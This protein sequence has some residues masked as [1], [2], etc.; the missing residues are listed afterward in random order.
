MPSDTESLRLR[1]RVIS[2][3]AH[4]SRLLIVEALEQGE[5]T[6]TELTGIVGSDISTVSRHLGVLRNAGI[7]DSRKDSNKVLHR[8]L[9]P[10]LT[11]FLK[12]VEQVLSETCGVCR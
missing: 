11:N 2:S 10:C 1:A 12:C 7:I 4:P 9:T 3:L 8:L 5:K 6:V